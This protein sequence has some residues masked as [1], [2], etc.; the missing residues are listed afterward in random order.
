MVNSA[1]LLRSLLS[2]ARHQWRANTS[3]CDEDTRLILCSAA[4]RRSWLAHGQA[5]WRA[6]K[7]ARKWRCAFQFASCVGSHCDGLS[8]LSPV[9]GLHVE[10]Q[11]ITPLPT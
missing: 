9:C 11:T 2:R 6:N 4:T 8:T 3:V 7:L 1:E 10:R 5:G